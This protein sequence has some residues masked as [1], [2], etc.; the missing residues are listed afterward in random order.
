MGTEKNTA[1]PL[2]DKG[3]QGLVKSRTPHFQVAVTAGN[4]QGQKS[5]VNKGKAWRALGVGGSPPNAPMAVE[6][7][8]KDTLAII[9]LTSVRGLWSPGL[10]NP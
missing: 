3:S 2:E 7:H 10:P 9:S 6:V 8:D 5:C 4:K 1:I